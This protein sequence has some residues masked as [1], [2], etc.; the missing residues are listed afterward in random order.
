MYLFQRMVE[1]KRQADSHRQNGRVQRFWAQPGVGGLTWTLFAS[2]LPTWGLQAPLS[3]FSPQN[4]SGKYTQRSCGG[5]R[6]RLVSLP[7]RSTRACSRRHPIYNQLDKHCVAIRWW[8]GYALARPLWIVVFQKGADATLCDWKRPDSRRAKPLQPSL[9][10]GH[11]DRRIQQFESGGVPPRY[12]NVHASLRSLLAGSPEDATTLHDHPILPADRLGA[13]RH[14][15][16]A[17]IGFPV[18]RGAPAHVGPSPLGRVREPQQRHHEQKGGVPEEGGD[19]QHRAQ[20]QVE[21]GQY[22]HQGLGGGHEPVWRYAGASRGSQGEE[23]LITEAG[24]P[25]VRCFTFWNY[26]AHD[27][28]FFM[29]HISLFHRSTVPPQD[30][31]YILSTR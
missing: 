1:I 6:C 26:I 15:R 8:L 31:R 5:G 22:S 2:M 7:E 11:E 27:R 20:R 10:S 14:L 13:Q 21:R 19:A 3:K 17:D 16:Q 4:G 12:R 25:E 9:P 18:H 24:G 30:T 29:P 23:R 28:W